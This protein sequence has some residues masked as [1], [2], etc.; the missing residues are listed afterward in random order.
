[1]MDVIEEIIKFRKDLEDAKKDVKGINDKSEKSAPAKKT[2]PAK[3]ASTK[4]A[5]KKKPQ[6][7]EKTKP[8]PK[9]VKSTPKKQPVPTKKTK[10]KPA[11][12]K[13]PVPAKKTKGEHKAKPALKKQPVP[14]KK[15]KAK[16][17]PKKQPIPAKKTKDEHKAKPAL[18]KQPVPVKKTKA[19]PAP[20]K[21]PVPAK[22]TKQNLKQTPKVKKTQDK[23]QTDGKKT[24]KS[25]DVPTKGGKP[26]LKKSK[27]DEKSKPEPEEEKVQTLEEQIEKEMSEDQIKNLEIEKANMEKITYKV[28]ELLATFA[29]NTMHQNQIWK[30]MR[31]NARDGARLALRLERRG[32]ISREKILDKG[33]WTYNLT[34][35][36]SP[37]STESIIKAPCL[38]CKVEQKCTLD[39]EVS[40]RTC[41]WINDW[42]L[43]KS[44]GSKSKK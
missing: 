8:I 18:K 6:I 33:R 22:K 17:A 10:A 41:Q 26:S 40:P 11:P 28:C 30:K 31:I 34:L 5:P 32:I 25:Q 7:V 12:K 3:G 9:A 19:K 24:V 36:K 29:S 23:K 13:Q 35:I 27:A 43:I 2:K 1:M 42:V 21:Q 20:K 44:T 16:P 15:T 14:T 39:G 4:A 37:I 38:T